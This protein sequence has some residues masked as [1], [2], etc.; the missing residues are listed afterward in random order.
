MV[1]DSA[2]E[3]AGMVD[4]GVDGAATVGVEMADTAAG[5][6][7]M[8]VDMVGGV[9]MVVGMGGVGIV[10]KWVSMMMLSTTTF[11]IPLHMFITAR[12]PA[13]QNPR[14]RMKNL[15]VDRE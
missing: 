7:D 6:A 9:E 11:D 8:D 12:V 14:K 13:V 15:D 3:V 10:K 2:V 5:M 1:V 4:M